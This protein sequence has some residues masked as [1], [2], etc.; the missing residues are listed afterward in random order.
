MTARA[1]TAPA[2]LHMGGGR[3]AARAA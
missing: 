2:L 1:G 3:D